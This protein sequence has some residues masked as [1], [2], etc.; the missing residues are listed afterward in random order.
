MD[1]IMLQFKKIGLE[2][3]EFLS[4][5]LE[6]LNC[7]LFNYSYVVLFIYR[8]SVNFEYALFG[9]FVIIKTC[10][11]G[12][13]RFMLPFGGG[14]LKEVLDEV[15]KYAFSKGDSCIFMQFC[16]NKVDLM[17][18][19]ADNVVCS[20]H[21][22]Y[23]FYPARNEY[24]YI[25]LAENLAELEGHFLKPKRNQINYFTGHFNWSEEAI[26]KNNL[27]EVMAFNEEWNFQKQ[28]PAESLLNGENMALNE[29]FLH[30][31]ELPLKGLVLRIDGK[32]VAFTI[33]CRLND[34]T[35]FVLFEKANSDFKGAYTMINRQFVRSLGGE[36]NY[37]NRADDAGVEGL[38]KAKLSYMPECLQK[39]HYL[40]LYRRPSNVP[41]D[42]F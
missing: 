15:R 19:W 23:D 35:F 6:K 4:A 38:R 11:H 26:D 18:N 39:V 21:Y 14:D 24:E 12:K 33:G 3:K 30:Y 41:D 28:I 2:D 16:E 32:I 37:I 8:N 17:L 25:Y 1:G 5:K 9:D 7:W 42:G 29:A 22:Y 36:Y 20:D 34:D 40:E 10:I 27:P 31:F 13:N